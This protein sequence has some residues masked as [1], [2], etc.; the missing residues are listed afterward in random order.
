MRAGDVR[1][2]SE[3]TTSYA[4]DAAPASASI[5]VNRATSVRGHG[6]CP[7]FASVASSMSTTLTGTGW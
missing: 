7:N 3:K 2:G 6:H 1:S 4:M 5:C